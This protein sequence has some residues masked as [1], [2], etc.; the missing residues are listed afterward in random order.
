[1]FV[2]TSNASQP[3]GCLLFLCQAHLSFCVFRDQSIK[4]CNSY[5]CVVFV[6]FVISLLLALISS[7]LT[8]FCSPFIT[9]FFVQEDVMARKFSNLYAYK[10]YAF[11]MSSPFRLDARSTHFLSISFRQRPFVSAGIGSALIAFSLALITG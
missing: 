4:C 2:L 6:P 3:V 8:A 5:C 10:F 1:M 7:V 9:I 11:E